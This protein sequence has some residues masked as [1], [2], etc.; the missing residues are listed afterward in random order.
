MRSL[1]DNPACYSSQPMA[2]AG[3][4]AHIWLTCQANNAATNLHTTQATV[5]ASLV[6]AVHLHVPFVVSTLCERERV[7][8]CVGKLMRTCSSWFTT[9]QAGWGTLHFI[10]SSWYTSSRECH[11]CSCFKASPAEPAAW[12][13]CCWFCCCFAGSCVHCCSAPAFSMLLAPSASA[14]ALCFARASC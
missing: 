8:V 6:Q 1:L 10:R 7:C 5:Q 3:I 9:N 12:S 11:C 2:G 13:I 4:D 14:A